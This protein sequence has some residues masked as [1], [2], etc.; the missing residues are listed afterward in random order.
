MLIKTCRLLFWYFLKDRMYYHI[1]AKR[2]SQ[3]LTGLGS[4]QEGGEGFH[5]SDYLMSKKPRM[6][7]AKFIRNV[8]VYEIKHENS[9]LHFKNISSL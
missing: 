2:H 9:F 6:V 3:C 5:P 8:I 4:M 7:R 1:H